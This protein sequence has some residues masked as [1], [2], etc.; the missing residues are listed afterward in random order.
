MRTFL[1]LIAF[2]A[3]AAASSRSHADDWAIQRNPF[4]PRLVA[5][6]KRLLESQPNSSYALDRIVRLYRTHSTAKRLL[7]EYE[8]KA[9]AKP[10]SFALQ[11]I[12]GRLCERSAQLA[13]ALEHYLAASKLRPKSS[14]SAELVARLYQRLGRHQEAQKSYE[15]AL[16]LSHS[17]GRKKRILRALASSALAAGNSERGLLHLRALLALA[18][19]STTIQVE[20]ATVLVRLKR[21]PEALAQYQQVL[22]RTQDTAVR[23]D[24][25]REMGK[26]EESLGHHDAAIATYRKAMRLAAHGHFL[27]KELTDRIISIHRHR[28]DLATLIRYYERKWKR[29]GHFEWEVLARLYD[30]TGSEEHAT[31]AYRQALTSNPRAIETRTR[32]IALLERSGNAAAVL[33]QVRMLVS[34]A[35]G[36]PRYQID[37][38]RRLHASGLLVD[39]IRVLE[40]CGRRFP[41]DAGVHAALADL[42]GRWGERAR[43]MR[44]A[45]I[46]VQIEPHDD[47]H[48]INLG[49]QLFQQ[50]KK[51]QAL[52]TWKR[53]L[54]VIPQ[55]H[56]ALAQLAAVHAEHDLAETAKTYYEHAIA[57][58]PKFIPYLRSL[59]LLLE[60][61]RRDRAALVY[62]RRIL[63]V[64]AEQQAARTAREARSHL[65]DIAHRTYALRGE[66]RA[67]QRRFERTPPDIDAGLFL[68]E[69]YRKLGNLGSAAKVYREIVSKDPRQ[70]EAWQALETVYRQQ[71]RLARAV[72]VLKRLAEL[73]PG[74]RKDYYQRIANLQLRL[75]ND[76]EALRYGHLALQIGQQDARSYARLAELYEQREDFD[77]ALEALRKAVELSPTLESARFSLARLFVKRGA[78]QEAEGAYRGL[79]RRTKKPETARRAFRKALVLSSYLG[80][81][82]A[83]ERDLVARAAQH[84][85]IAETYR[86]LL[87][88]LYQR[89]VPRLIYEARYADPERRRRANTALLKI[90]VRGMAPL[91]DDLANSATNLERKLQVVTM[92]G[93]LGNANATP[94]LLR[95]IASTTPTPRA[96]VIR[97]TGP[98]YGAATGDRKAMQMRVAAT[99]AL[100]RLADPK[101]LRALDKLLRGAREGILREAAAWA[102]SQYRSPG[103]EH[104]LFSALGD[105][106]SAVQMFACV[107]LGRQGRAENIPALEEV[108]LDHGRAEAVRAACAWALGALG[109]KSALSTLGS[110]FRSGEEPVQ[111]CA[112]WA[113]GTIGAAEGMNQLVDGLWSRRRGV[114]DTVQWAILKLLGSA[115]STAPAPP[116]IRLRDGRIDR[117]HYLDRL[118][119]HVRAPQAERWRTLISAAGPVREQL[120]RALAAGVARALGRHRD[121]AL[122]ALR[123][124]DANPRH[125]ALGKMFASAPKASPA[126]LTHQRQLQA[127]VAA[128]IERPIRR[129]LQHPDPEIASRAVGVFIKMRLKDTGQTLVAIWRMSHRQVQERI[130]SLM[131]RLPTTRGSLPLQIAQIA[132]QSPHWEVREQLSMLIGHLA[133]GEQRA[134]IIKALLKDNS[135]FVRDAVVAAI[136]RLKPLPAE[137]PLWLDH[138]SRDPLAEV[139]RSVVRSARRAG[140]AKLRTTIERLIRDRDPHVATAAA[141]LVREPSSP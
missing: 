60:R 74:Q 33:A 75:Y 104:A 121:I 56:K 18:P 5:R 107:G 76:S 46:L 113:I 99:V 37:L 102:L 127:V 1:A 138:A 38:G 21:H 117:E 31:K 79:L 58:Q 7:A 95:I 114:R 53:L 106:R 29:R 133:A 97:P 59:A 19:Q 90:G 77:H 141:Q 39:A 111:R 80:R 51:S 72:Q 66:M 30:E 13:R 67:S 78:F 8:G 62:W 124:L 16:A 69:G 130:V 128:A 61:K 137:L 126:T 25:L 129:L 28:D 68:A 26:L 55:R 87:V 54:T 9:R 71:R 65:I 14:P 57:L 4:D 100:G 101:A 109:A 84:S 112:G 85:P 27:R 89:S 139:R 123:A 50:G 125:I 42:Y 131:A 103:A 20:V 122:R 88:S 73:Q 70:I 83:L 120:D 47:A 134:A 115:V 98:R 118:T 81:V 15:Q 94:A 64:A 24:I 140:I 44:E 36:E 34:S 17:D 6:Y 22:K 135:G 12:V 108:L 52:Q 45:R 116:D 91:L 86:R 48:L 49:E 82:D 93:Y 11:V 105:R 3:L 136:G 110:V 32:Y 41:K 23:A 132:L 35:P 43:A 40:T 119:E 2:A 96:L 92:L 10:R 63:T